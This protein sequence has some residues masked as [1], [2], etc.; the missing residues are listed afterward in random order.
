MAAAAAVTTVTMMMNAAKSCR[1][2][3]NL[4]QA[5]SASSKTPAGTRR[6]ES[7]WGT[8]PKPHLPPSFSSATVLAS[9]KCRTS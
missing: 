1:V 9:S 5:V 7:K 2:S 8:R 3:S 4:T 6:R